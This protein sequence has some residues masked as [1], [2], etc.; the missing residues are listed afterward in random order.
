[1]LSMQ[2]MKKKTKR[3]Y[4]RMQHGIGKK[5]EQID[6]LLQKRKAI[7]DDADEP[8]EESNGEQ[9]DEKKN[10]TSNNNKKAKTTNNNKGKKAKK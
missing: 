2:M 5:Q 6:S 10:K 7:E 4:D 8:E 3:L 9:E 1:M